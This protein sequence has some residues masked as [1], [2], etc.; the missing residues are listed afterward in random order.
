MKLYTTLLLILLLS[1][2][3]FGQN[4]I[5]TTDDGE[6]V[7][8]KPNNTW[9]YAVKEK[10]VDSSALTIGWR[11]ISETKDNVGY[12]YQP[13]TVKTNYSS[14]KSFWMRVV[15]M[16]P[17]SFVKQNKFPPQTVYY[18]A[19]VTLDCTSE[20]Y[21]IEQV[22]LYDSKGEIINS[23]RSWGSVFYEKSIP[24]TV[25]QRWLNEICSN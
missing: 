19:F 18:H 21:S 17:R 9:E 6:R 14:S 16:Y 20:R 24:G 3:A 23:N 4:K 5:A 13:Q 2:A 15:P 1:A 7:I 25:G 12:Y 11:L 22:V 10:I 8:L